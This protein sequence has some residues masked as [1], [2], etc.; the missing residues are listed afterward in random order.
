MPKPTDKAAT[1]AKS[2]KQKPQNKQ[3]VRRIAHLQAVA[4]LLAGQGGQAGQM[5][6]RQH[7]EALF[8]LAEK[9]Q[10]RPPPLLRRGFCRR[11]RLPLVSGVT[12][13]I[14]CRRRRRH[15]RMVGVV[16]CRLCRSF[17]TYGFRQCDWIRAVL[18]GPPGSQLIC[19]TSAVPRLH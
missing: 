8:T 3:A 16:T 12:A 13:D 4:R 18:P 5:L 9:S 19:E 1:T 6:A 17:A 11:C 15:R 10:T 7:A 2:A 14:R